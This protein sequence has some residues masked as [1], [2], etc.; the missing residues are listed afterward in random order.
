LPFETAVRPVVVVVVLSFAKLVIEQAD[1]VS[2]AVLVQQ[3][4]EL[5]FVH[6]V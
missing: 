3:L 2:D 6:A 4:V 5:S 1:I